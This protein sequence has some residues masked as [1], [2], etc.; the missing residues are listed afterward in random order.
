M[1]KSALIT[2]SP[3]C[4]ALLT[5]AA[6]ISNYAFTANNKPDKLKL[7][8][9]SNDCLY[10]AFNSTAEP[11][12]KKWELSITYDN[13]LRFRKTYYNGRQVYFS[14]NIS[15]FQDLDYLG[16]T[17]NGLLCLKVQANDIITQTFHD[18]KGDVDSMSTKLII[19]AKNM[20]PSRLDSLRQTLL[21]LKALR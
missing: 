8:L 20:E 4:V 1:L 13:F 12:L 10:A 19:P 5:I 15:R 16:T 18:P 3:I 14:F 11:Q 7:R 6:I 9:W 21:Q 2:A 17:K